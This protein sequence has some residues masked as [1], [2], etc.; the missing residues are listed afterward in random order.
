VKNGILRKKGKG[1]NHA[2][3]RDILHRVRRRE[4]RREGN[5]R[6]DSPVSIDSTDD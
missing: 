6:E 2:T 1:N 5:R 3:A 4:E